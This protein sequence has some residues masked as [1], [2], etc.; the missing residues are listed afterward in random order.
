MGAGC[1]PAVSVAGGWVSVAAGRGGNWKGKERQ[2]KIKIPTQN[3]IYPPLE[4]GIYNIANNPYRKR[5]TN[6]IRLFPLACYASN[7][8]V[9][10]PILINRSSTSLSL[11]FGFA[12][13][14]FICPLLIYVSKSPRNK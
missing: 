5:E 2:Y 3:I 12:N 7:I 4:G 8:S 1:C 9:S 10:T 14:T 11:L 6:Q 13:S